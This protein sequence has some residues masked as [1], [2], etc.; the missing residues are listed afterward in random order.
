VVSSSPRYVRNLCT[1]IKQFYAF[2][3]ERGVIADDSFA[4]ALWRRRE[5]AARVVELFNRL[6]GDTPNFDLLF[7]R[8]F[9]PYTN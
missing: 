5:E 3:K 2:L 8:L 6:S 7:Q 9:A 1:S 4:Q